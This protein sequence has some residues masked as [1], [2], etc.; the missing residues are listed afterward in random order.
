MLW[1]GVLAEIKGKA[2]SPGINARPG[3][4]Q[5]VMVSGVRVAC[6]GPRRNIS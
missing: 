6:T 1:P 5:A 3:T 4:A 2:L